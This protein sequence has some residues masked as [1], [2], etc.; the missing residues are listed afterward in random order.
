M[1][2]YHVSDSRGMVKLD[3]MENPYHVAAGALRART[4]SRWRPGQR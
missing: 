4:G 3:A 2:A 1:A